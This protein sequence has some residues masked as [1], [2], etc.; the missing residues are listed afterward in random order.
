M[1][2]IIFIILI[3]GFLISAGIAQSSQLSVDLPVGYIFSTETTSN[4][5][6]EQEFMGIQYNTQM[7]TGSTI[8]FQ[9]SSFNGDS[10]YFLSASY[11]KMNIRVTSL[12]INMEVN[13]ESIVS[14]DSLSVLL[15]LL[16]GKAFF[17]K[18]SKKGEI[19]EVSGLDEMIIETVKSSGFSE[20]E[21][22]EFTRNLIQSLGTEAILDN[23]RSNKAFY[24]EVN[25]KTTD[26]WDFEMALFKNG[27]PMKLSSHIRLKELSKNT[28]ILVSEGKISS[29]NSQKQTESSLPPEQLYYLVGSEVS[30]I[31]I[32]TRTGLIRESIVSQNITG[33]IK[34]ISA[35]G[36]P[37]V[38]L[39][40]FKIISRITMLTNPSK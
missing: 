29:D 2:G 26:Q 12:L 32:N 28:A 15:S 25:V 17:V 22:Y 13:S 27:I 6:V 33:T 18:L 24:P 34:T 40:P 21:R 9:V 14:G 1:K 35:E 20:E 30:E 39:I 38:A 10:A 37:D 19:T 23:Y 16:K 7:E 11:E 4:L 8:R 3:Q 36:S 5:V 31:K